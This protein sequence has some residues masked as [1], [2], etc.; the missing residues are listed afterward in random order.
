MTQNLTLQIQNILSKPS[1]N[2]RELIDQLK[3]AVHAKPK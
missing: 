3:V 2:S 1:D